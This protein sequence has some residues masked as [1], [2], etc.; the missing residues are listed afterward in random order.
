MGERKQTNIK[1]WTYYFYNDIDL[2]EFDGSKTKT[3]K[4]KINDIG[5]YYLRYEYKKT[6]TECN[7]INSVNSLY[8]RIIDMKGQF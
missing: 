7:V 1:N 2:D 4:K 3:D 6:I 5:I 8:L